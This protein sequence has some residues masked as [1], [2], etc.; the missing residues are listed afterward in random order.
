M[1]WLGIGL[2]GL[3]E[4]KVKVFFS[5]ELGLEKEGKSVWW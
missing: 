1:L 5:V 2:F 4:K 3:G